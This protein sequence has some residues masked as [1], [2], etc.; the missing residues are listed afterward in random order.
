MVGRGARR[1]KGK[2]SFNIVE[3]TDNVERFV[4]VWRKRIFDGTGLGVPAKSAARSRK[5]SHQFDPT[6]APTWTSGNLPDVLRDIWYREGQTFGVEFELTCEG[7]PETGPDDDEWCRIADELLARLR[8]RLGSQRVR[9]EPEK[10]YHTEGYEQWKVEY[11]SSVGWEVVSPVLSGIE[12]LLELVG[13][14]EALSDAV[15]D[16]DLG[17]VLNYR[18]GTHVHIGWF[19]EDASVARAL[20]ITHLLEPLLRSLVP[21]SRFAA[22]D[23]EHDRYD[24]GRPNDYCRPVSSVYAIDDLDEE[25]TLG[26]LE[27]MADLDPAGWGAHGNFQS[28]AAMGRAR[29]AC[30][31]AAAGWDHR[32]WEAHPLAKP[33]DADSVGCGWR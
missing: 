5:W 26:D 24:T 3:F 11:D 15:F 9:R 2:N 31:G 16:E 23:P 32:G 22:Y 30:G 20:R 25:T 6:G 19:A 28:D 8:D 21:P 13:A 4:D 10:E 33:L 12:G 27:E 18:T 17:L 1:E 29:A 14:C 7:Y